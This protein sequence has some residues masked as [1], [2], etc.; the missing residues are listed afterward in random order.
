[1]SQADGG[2]VIAYLQP[3]V[4]RMTARKEGFGTLIR[5]GIKLDV[6]Q[7]ARIDFHLQPS[8]GAGDD[9]R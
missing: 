6:A 2:Y 7:P 5:F 3:G 1:M 4:Y 8:S 9:H